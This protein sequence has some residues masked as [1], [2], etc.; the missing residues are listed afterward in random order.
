LNYGSKRLRLVAR[1]SREG[2]EFEILVWAMDEEE[3]ARA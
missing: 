2:D 1:N 3:R